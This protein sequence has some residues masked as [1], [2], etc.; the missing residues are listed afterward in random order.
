MKKLKLM[1]DYECFPLWE[2]NGQIGNIDPYSLPISNSLK[3]ELVS[4]GEIY[5]ATLNIDDPANSG[6][7]NF[8]EEIEFKTKAYE[9]ADKLRIE[10]GSDYLIEVKV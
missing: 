10:L 9:L 8:Q 7:C 3:E 4:W 1:A 6:F 5:D 2:T